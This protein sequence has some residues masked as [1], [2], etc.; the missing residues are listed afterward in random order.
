MPDCLTTECI[1]N[2]LFDAS[3]ESSPNGFA[4]PTG[5][6]GGGVLLSLRN[7]SVGIGTDGG[8]SG[9]AGDASAAP[10]DLLRCKP[11]P[12]P[13]FLRF[14]AGESDS[15]DVSTAPGG[16]LRCLD[17]GAFS[18]VPVYGSIVGVGAAET[19]FRMSEDLCA[20]PEGGAPSGRGG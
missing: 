4:S 14:G 3:R 5:N 15:F 9:Y 2:P 18:A 12:H 19:C 13:S 6:G 11:W 8:R 17:N 10:V 1:P 16:A 7:S 20:V